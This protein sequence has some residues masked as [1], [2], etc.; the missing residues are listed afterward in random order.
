MTSIPTETD[1]EY[2]EEQKELDFRTFIGR[3]KKAQEIR[4]SDDDDTVTVEYCKNE[5]EFTDAYISTVQLLKLKL[6][7]KR[8]NELLAAM[9]NRLLPKEMMPKS[10]LVYYVHQKSCPGHQR[11][12]KNC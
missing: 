4:T 3:N 1:T 5:E 2:I 6:E 10:D 11:V 12:D 9:F 8:V 7:P